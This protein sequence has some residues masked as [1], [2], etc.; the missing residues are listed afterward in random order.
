[1]RLRPTLFS[2]LILLGGLG[3]A[4][5]STEFGGKAGKKTGGKGSDDSSDDGG[6]D[7][8]GDDGKDDPKDAA[9]DTGKPNPDEKTGEEEEIRTTSDEFRGAQFVKPLEPEQKGRIW[10]ATQQGFAY[11]FRLD[12]DK[13]VETK[14]WTGITGGDGGARTYVTEGGLVVARS[15]GRLFFIDPEAPE[16]AVTNTH[17][18]AGVADNQR[19]CVVSYRRDKKRYIGMGYANGKFIEWE[20][21]S[22]KPYAPKWTA[23]RMASVGSAQWG[24]SC[25]IDQTRLVYY[26]DF[27]NQVQA[28]DLKTMQSVPATNAP[29]GSFT[30]TNIASATVGP[31]RAA[32]YAIAGD[33]H[34]NVL[35]GD[36]FYTFTHEAKT[37]T[38]WG[39]GKG[40]GM[41]DV[42]PEK[43]FDK[44]PNCSGFATYN[45]VQVAAN[46]QPISALGDGKVI[47]IQRAGNKGHVYMMTLKNPK[48]AT[49]GVDAVRIAE[50]DG[51]PYMYTDFTGA[52]LYMTKSV[53]TFDLDDDKGF[54]AGKMNRGV[55]FSWAARDGTS[56]EWDDLSFE[57]RCY[58]A[59]GDRGDYED[60]TPIKASPEMTIIRAGGCEN[61]QYD[62]VDIRLKQENDGDSLMNVRKMQVNV[63][64]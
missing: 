43:C 49:Q 35:N 3:W 62:R 41:L 23:P 56:N 8:G 1:M 9:F 26:G 29:N 17:R 38:V 18:V 24:Y 10:A 11:Y 54:K 27:H 36:K 16:G 31:K 59:G 20:L 7:D 42:Y 39:T 13:V 45:T 22:S 47:G 32:S 6:D 12:G 15:G 44:E 53:N 2:L 57:I 25:F 63:F 33:S 46:A 60:V 30:S 51:D 48:D 58:K 14:K 5:S 34:G 64:Q 50:V 21:E 37:K 55:G 19:G 28:L 52:T 4:C 61:K 40:G